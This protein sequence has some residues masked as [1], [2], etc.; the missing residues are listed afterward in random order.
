L[1]TEEARL[2]DKQD[3][4]VYDLAVVDGA[5]LNPPEELKIIMEDL[6]L[7]VAFVKPWLVAPAGDA[8]TK[9]AALSG[10]NQRRDAW[11]KFRREK[12]IAAREMS[13]YGEL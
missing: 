12:L 7:F 5:Q 4:L 11:L 8:A 2:V 3:L 9:I 13:R 1:Y 6:R 10:H